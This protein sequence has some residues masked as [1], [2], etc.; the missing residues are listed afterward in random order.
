ML[1]FKNLFQITSFQEFRL[2]HLKLLS[3]NH[4]GLVNKL[5]LLFLKILSYLVDQKKKLKN[6][7][8]SV[9]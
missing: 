3:L 4:F 1:V 5:Y 7:K 9:G 2:Y 8:N 6:Y